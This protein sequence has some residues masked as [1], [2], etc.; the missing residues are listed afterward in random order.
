MIRLYFCALMAVCVSTL[1]YSYATLRNPE[2]YLSLNSRD[3]LRETLDGPEN[4]FV[5][6]TQLQAR[7][8]TTVPRGAQD[9]AGVS[10]D[11][12]ALMFLPPV[13][14]SSDASFSDGV[15]AYD[16]EKYP[17]PPV[18]GVLSLGLGGTSE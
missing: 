15:I 17:V 2:F 3:N 11:T 16:R 7:T 5:T 6:L 4:V 12:A 18:A 8:V 1:H 13:S 9:T 10:A 14:V